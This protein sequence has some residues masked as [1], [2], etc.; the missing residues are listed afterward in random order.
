MLMRILL[1]FS[2]SWV[3]RLTEP[4]FTVLSQEISGR[5]LI[6]IVGGL[7]LLGKS[8]YEIH[9]KLEGEEGHGSARVKATFGAVPVQIIILTAD[10]NDVEPCSLALRHATLDGSIVFMGKSIE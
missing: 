1:L 2:L 4:L 9:D 8:T 3:I 6:L 10:C 7:F 5:D